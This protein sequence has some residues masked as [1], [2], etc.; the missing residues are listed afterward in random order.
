MIDLI[1]LPFQG[2]WCLKNEKK[3]ILQD[4]SKSKNRMDET[5]SSCINSYSTQIS[6]NEN[7]NCGQKEYINAGT[8]LV[9][10]GGY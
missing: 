5:A 4:I 2:V 6:C 10:R 9:L 7:Q 1:P 3:N 8:S